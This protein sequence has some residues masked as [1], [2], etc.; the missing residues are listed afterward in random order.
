M[1]TGYLLLPKTTEHLISVL[2]TT[3]DLGEFYKYATIFFVVIV[4]AVI[5]DRAFSLLKAFSRSKM[6][7]IKAHQYRQDYMNMDY[8]H[9]L[10][11]GTGKAIARI[12]KGI[13]AEVNI[14]FTMIN[15][16]INVLF[17]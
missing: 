12:E 14:F 9:I 1:H 6:Y 16:A 13:S 15:I 8:S 17:R 3:K 7:I 10:N 11:L 2:E 5:F 4:L